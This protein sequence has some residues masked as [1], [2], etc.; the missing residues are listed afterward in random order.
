MGASMQAIR[1]KAVLLGRLPGNQKGALILLTLLI[2]LVIS[3]LGMSSVDSTGL[4]MK[5]SS[6][7][8]E[9][10]QAFEAAEYTLSWVEN[11]LATTGY[12]STPSVTN[13]V[14][15]DAGNGLC[16]A[17]CFSSIGTNGYYFNGDITPYSDPGAWDTCALLP[18]ATEPY[19]DPVTWSTSDRHRTLVIPNSDIVAKYII[20][21]WCYTA[22]NAGVLDAANNKRMYRITA[23]TVGESGRAR[24]MLRSTVMEP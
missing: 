12:F 15:G 2:L 19:A 16:G 4:E 14:D 7:S 13:D 5:M 22:P 8:R 23:Y 9:Q 3:M 18:P 10:Q 11:A 24:V 20:E 17:V 6:N 21:Y 1:R